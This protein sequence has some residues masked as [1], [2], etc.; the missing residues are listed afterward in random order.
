M[1]QLQAMRNA[2]KLKIIN[3]CEGERIY[4]ADEKKWDTK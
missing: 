4:K 1:M 2:K 3:T